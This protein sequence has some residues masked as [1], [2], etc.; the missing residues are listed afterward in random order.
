MYIKRMVQDL[1][2]HFYALCHLNVLRVKK[3]NAMLHL[4]TANC[5]K[6]IKKYIFNFT[7]L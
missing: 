2:R 4:Q 3:S 1:F 6:N 5:W 7:K